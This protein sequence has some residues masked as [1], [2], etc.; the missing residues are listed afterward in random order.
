MIAQDPMTPLNSVLTIGSQVEEPQTIDNG[1]SQ[2][3]AL[4]RLVEILSLIGIPNACER[5]NN[6]L[7]QFSGWI[8]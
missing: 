4:A 2:T 7:H 6:C 3:E 5:L 1:M 8:R